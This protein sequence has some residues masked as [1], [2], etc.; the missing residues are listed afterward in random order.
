M[1][2]LIGLYLQ[3]D[4]KEDNST[5]FPL[6]RDI[7]I[8]E[9]IADKSEKNQL[10]LNDSQVIQEKVNVPLK[11]QQDKLIVVNDDNQETI[12]SEKT[13]QLEKYFKA[14]F[15]AA[16]SVIKQYE[17]IIKATFEREQDPDWSIEAEK[18]LI[19]M[20]MQLKDK[21]G[22]DYK[23][24]KVRCSD[25]TCFVALQGD[26]TLGQFELTKLFNKPLLNI[27]L[28]QAF[29]V[30]VSTELGELSGI[31]VHRFNALLK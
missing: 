29:D 13:R 11:E 27:H 16:E 30:I 4:S 25:V 26:L 12:K 18:R 17:F 3:F 15:R 9:V 5:Y 1:L 22:L 10:P 21:Y 8:D 19:E 20:G 28:F 24:T 23:V 2:V 14:T 7:V 31:Y 6:P